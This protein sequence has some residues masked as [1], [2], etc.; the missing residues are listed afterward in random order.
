MVSRKEASIV[1]DYLSMSHVKRGR[2]NMSSIT[3]TH[4][5]HSHEKLER[6]SAEI[7]E[8]RSVRGI[9]WIRMG[10]RRRMR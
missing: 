3:L 8:R 9:W 5:T 1:S 4:T 6:V 2:K 7:M 10:W